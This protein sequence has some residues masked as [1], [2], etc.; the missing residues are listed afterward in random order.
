MMTRSL[1]EQSLLRCDRRS[2]GCTNA[3][4][5]LA[6]SDKAAASLKVATAGRKAVLPRSIRRFLVKAGFVTAGFG[7]A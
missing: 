5:Q 3:T 7:A 2:R 1:P 4:V 6:D